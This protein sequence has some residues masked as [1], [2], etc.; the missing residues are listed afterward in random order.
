MKFYFLAASILLI[1]TAAVA[2]GTPSPNEKFNDVVQRI[3]SI[4]S[5]IESNRSAARKVHDTILFA[6]LNDAANQV[7]AAEK[8]L[9]GKYYAPSKQD[10]N[11]DDKVLVYVQQIESEAN[12]C[13]GATSIFQLSS[14]KTSFSIDDSIINIDPTL[15]TINLIIDP[16]NCASCFR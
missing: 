16:P 3:K 6:C 4:Q 9:E 10:A 2:D 7:H 15:P 8:Q 12:N 5:K 14:Y 1:A 11:T 13:L